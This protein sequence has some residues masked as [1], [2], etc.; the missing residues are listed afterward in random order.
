MIDDLIFLRTVSVE[1]DA[2]IIGIGRSRWVSIPPQQ[3]SVENAIILM[4]KGR[5]DVLPI[6]PGD[7][8][9]IYDYFSTTYSHRWT[10][11][12]V[13]RCSLT[14]RDVLSAKTPVIDLIEKLVLRKR[15]FFFLSY[16]NKVAGL[17]SLVNLN[18]R[19]VRV[20]LYSLICEFETRLIR[21]LKQTEIGAENIFLEMKET[22][23][24]NYL[25][26]Q[27]SGYDNDITEY[28]YLSDLLDIIRKNELHKTMGY[29]SSNHFK[30]LNSLNELRNQVMHPQRSLVNTEASLTQLWDRIDRLQDALFRLRQL[31][32]FSKNFSQ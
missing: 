12:T 29:D 17:V 20:Y 7:S 2:A 9:P 25:K 26:D 30:K 19:E 10:S 27:E 1:V 22:A 28:L 13:H 21:L 14:H 16:N 8:D 11:D 32:S 15:S 5:F 3:A 6:D 23:K 18:S 4:A 31:Q 24:A